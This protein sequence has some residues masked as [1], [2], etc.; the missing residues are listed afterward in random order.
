MD[1]NVVSIDVF[2]CVSESL[3]AVYH[4]YKLIVSWIEIKYVEINV[5]TGT[6]KKYDSHQQTVAVTDTGKSTLAVLL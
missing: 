2:Y 4:T 3:S 6:D 5:F 1:P